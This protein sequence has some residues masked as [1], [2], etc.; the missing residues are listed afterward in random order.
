[1]NIIYNNIHIKNNQFLKVS[2]TQEKPK[3]KLE[4]LDITKTYLL[5]MYDP[6][7]VGGTHIH[8]VLSNITNMNINNGINLIPYK[9]PAPPP[10]TGKH[11]YIFELYEQN[12]LNLDLNEER[13]ILIENL[14]KKLGV[15]LPINK[16]QFISQ[17]EKGGKKNKTYKRKNKKRKTRKIKN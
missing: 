6:D 12:I 17:N 5:I 14:R 2:Q 1:M 3:I 11:R 10:G 4:S 7:A 9:G 13:S 16:I 15:N 8:W